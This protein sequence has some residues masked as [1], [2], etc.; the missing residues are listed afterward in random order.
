MKHKPKGHSTG[1]HRHQGSE[2]VYADDDC[3]ICRDEYLQE[4]APALLARCKTIL[5][6]LPFVDVAAL[7]RDIALAEGGSDG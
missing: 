4:A 3:P 2:S 5:R 1:K 7:R 6:E